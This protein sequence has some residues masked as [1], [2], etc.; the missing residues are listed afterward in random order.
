MPGPHAA[1][2]HL[3]YTSGH[4]V[5]S[6]M[7]PQYIRAMARTMSIQVRLSS[8][9]KDGF[10]EAADLAGISLSA[11]IRERL[12]LAAIRELEA[13]GRRPAFVKPIRLEKR[14]D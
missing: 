2:P 10:T 6:Y 13:A 11:W 5:E 1:Y 7:Q 12:R 9:E 8:D 4:V 3:H 14:D